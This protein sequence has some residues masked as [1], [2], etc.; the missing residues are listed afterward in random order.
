MTDKTPHQL[1]IESLK[2]HYEN[3]KAV[4]YIKHLDA[5]K[6]DGVPFDLDA[7][8]KSCIQCKHCKCRDC[9]AGTDRPL[10]FWDKL[11]DSCEPCKV[12]WRKAWEDGDVKGS[13]YLDVTEE[14]D[15]KIPRGVFLDE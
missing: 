7:W 14:E 4:T 8:D 1:V 2:K 5:L 11:P 10:W 12:E 3:T 9:V 6:W 15:N 13:W